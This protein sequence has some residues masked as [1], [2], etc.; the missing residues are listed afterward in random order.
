VLC[1]RRRHF[2]ERSDA[3]TPRSEG[4]R[5][6]AR[7]RIDPRFRVDRAEGIPPEASRG[8]GTSMRGGPLFS[9]LPLS[10]DPL[11]RETEAEAEAGAGKARMALHTR[12]ECR[13]ALPPARGPVSDGDREAKGGRLIS[14][15]EMREPQGS[16]H[17]AGKGLDYARRPTS[18]SVLPPA[19]GPAARP[20]E[21]GSFREAK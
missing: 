20:R 9:R 4:H 15:S 21:G 18:D 8:A 17:G 16:H 11:S 6:G 10:V 3:A 5:A 12:S 14:R 1:S 19:R 2:P 7:I 13:R